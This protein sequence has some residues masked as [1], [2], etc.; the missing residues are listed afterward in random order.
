M[1]IERKTRGLRG[2]KG[3]SRGYKGL[4]RVTRGYKGLQRVTGGYKGLQRITETRF[5]TR[6]S[7]ISFLGLILVK[8]IVEDI[9]N[10]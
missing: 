2:L 9:S 1:M 8:I 6:T 5:L 7:P 10:F 4:Q 3:I